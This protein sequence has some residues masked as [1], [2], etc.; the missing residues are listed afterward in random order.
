[1]A[2]SRKWVVL[3]VGVA[4][5]GIAAAP[6]TFAQQRT[7]DLPAEPASRSLPEFAR[8]ARIELIAPGSRL[9][10]VSTPALKGT[11]DVRV[12]LDHLLAGTG[13]HVLAQ[14][15]ERFTLGMLDERAST[16]AAPRRYAALVVPAP[17]PSAAANPE[18]EVAPDVVVVS[19][20]GRTQRLQDVPVSVSVASGEMLE[21][22]DL[23]NL[24]EVSARLP[25][26]K[27][28][29]APVS[30]FVTIRGVGSSLNPGFEQSV[31]TF[32]DGVYRGRSRS[33]R[34]ALFDIDRVE[35]LKGPQTT[36]F[37]N[38][39]IAGAINITTRKPSDH[40]EENAQAF[41][42]PNT[43][44]YAAE[45]GASIPLTD[46]LAIR[47][48]G[49]ASGMDG[50]IR[51][52]HLGEKGPHLSDKVGRISAKWTP[53]SILETDARID[54]GFQHDT[55]VFDAE[56][57]GCPPTLG[58]AGGPCARYLAANNRVVD[59]VLNGRSE[60]DPSFFYYDF[61]E[62]EIN[63][64]VSLGENALTFTT[65]YFHHHSHLFND[66]LPIPANQGGSVV[67]GPFSL[68]ADLNE[69]YQQFSQEVRFVSPEDRTVSYIV[70]AYFSA[71]QLR[72]QLLQGYYFAP[73]GVASGGQY[74]PTTPVVNNIDNNEN[75]QT[76][77][78]F[79]AVT[80]RPIDPLK[81]NLGGRYTN[82]HKHAGRAAV[83]GTASGFAT[84]D[85]FVPGSAATQARL[86]P[87]LATGVGNYATPYRSDS[88]FL[89]TASIQYTL[90]PDVMAYVSYS[91]GFKAGG[92][93]AMQNKSEFGPETVDDYE[94][95]LK[96]AF[97]DR[98][99]TFNITGFH[100][101]YKD[102]Q[103]STT[104][105]LPG[106][107]GTQIV[108]NVAASTS[109][110]IELG[111]T[112]QPIRPLLLNADVA[113]LNSQYDNYPNAPCTIVQSIGVTGCLQNL[114]GKRRAFAPAYSGNVG[115]TWNQ[116]VRNDYQASIST[117]VY[118]TTWFF[119]QPVADPILSQAGFA[120]LDMRIAFGRRDDLWEVALV[121]KNLTNRLT[122]SFRQTTVSALS[123]QALAD[124]P[125]SVGVQVTLHH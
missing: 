41:Y 62:G 54:A 47:L 112:V 55:G 12:A 57:I 97:L 7:F 35:I 70:G 72:N 49:K 107:I 125:R 78:G 38:N 23:R 80:I 101:K 63:N 6:G 42:A 71:S 14:D 116:E 87:A 90:A 21:K 73:L 74:G 33:T 34:A 50:Y 8:E 100:S 66:V 44:E 1:M 24:E 10:G 25:D 68:T 88:R 108:G 16:T 39:T 4:M 93:A 95:G 114:S 123:T 103:E 65:G 18:P 30:D 111:L 64:R 61:V 117:N 48:A 56:L 28:S 17:E 89:P 60:A 15:G 122:A 52:S 119:Q 84:E 26:V 106:G 83:V 118:F 22:S 102:L 69:H 9:R 19:A 91:K 109:K 85:N 99:V 31:G 32:V 75:A 96:S 51:N 104:V 45:A 29:T 77:S 120:K 67:G 58:P 113:Y 53:I 20:Q 59:D 124:P 3:R 81:I 5:L 46:D 82:V 40:L 115:A 2:K 110:G 13:L 121:G 37:G 98:K 27:I 76:K 36:F 11:Y 105:T 43:G 94:I 92:Y 79:A 86:L